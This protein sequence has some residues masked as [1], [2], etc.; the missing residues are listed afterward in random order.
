MPEGPSIVILR[1]QA[2]KFAGQRIR[3]VGGNSRLDIQRMAGERVAALRSWGKHFLLCFD[4]PD[5]G[6]FTLRVHFLLWGSYRIDERRE[7]RAERL[8]LAF[9]NGELN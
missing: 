4:P 2:A 5:S 3:G 8:S 6:N 1:E 9:D 7:G